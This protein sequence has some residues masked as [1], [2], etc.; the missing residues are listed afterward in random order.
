[1]PTNVFIENIASNNKIWDTAGRAVMTESG[2][3]DSRWVV[4]TLGVF[5]FPFSCFLILT[6]VLLNILVLFYKLHDRKG[7]DN[8][9][10]PK[11]LQ[12]RCL[13]P[14]CVFSFPFSCF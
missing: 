5:S 3:K 14:R 13:D 7:S 12:T 2:P 11:Q 8:G 4:W 10:G 6:N 1:M 9:N